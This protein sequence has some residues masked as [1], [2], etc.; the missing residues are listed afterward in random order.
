MIERS[1][2]LLYTCVNGFRGSRF[3]PNWDSI[4]SPRSG[5]VEEVVSWRFSPHLSTFPAFQVCGST[6]R[7]FR[8]CPFQSH[9]SNLDDL[10]QRFLLV[11][12]CWSILGDDAYWTDG[13]SRSMKTIAATKASGCRDAQG[14]WGPVPQMAHV[15]AIFATLS[16]GFNTGFKRFARFVLRV[17]CTGQPGHSV[18]RLIAPS[19]QHMLNAHLGRG[20]Y[21]QGR[22]SPDVWWWCTVCVYVPAQIY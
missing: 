12:S 6:F 15:T 14:L 18:G 1:Y 19:N 10:D 20:G 13:H 3:Q 22:K 11:G 7:K 2:K 4:C 5:L 9:P 16:E 8:R 17:L 21:V